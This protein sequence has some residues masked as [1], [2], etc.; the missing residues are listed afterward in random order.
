ME[1][2]TREPNYETQLS[3]IGCQ[4][5]VP[6]AVKLYLQIKTLSLTEGKYVKPEKRKT[7]IGCSEFFPG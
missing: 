1:P 2:N 6:T 7:A 3:S 5:A 4:Q